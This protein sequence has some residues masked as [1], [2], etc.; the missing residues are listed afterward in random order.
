MMKASL[1]I[2]GCIFI[3]VTESYSCWAIEMFG[4][5]CI[6]YFS[7]L[8]ANV[9]PDPL[10][11]DERCAVIPNSD[12]SLNWD[13][14]CFACLIFQRRIFKSYYFF[15][16]IDDT[17]AMTILASRGAEL[18]EDLRGKHVKEQEEKEKLIL[19][20]IKTKMDRIKENQRKIQGPT[21]KEPDSHYVGE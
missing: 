1:Q 5:G 11:N 8:F 19:E 2:L 14:L 12:V 10:D 7:D 20:N 15:H 4:I 6:R 16:I 3:R 18:I 21:Y 13:L 17:K 9:A